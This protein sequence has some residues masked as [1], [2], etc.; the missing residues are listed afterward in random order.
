VRSSLRSSLIAASV[1]IAP[2]APTIFTVNDQG[3]E[4]ADVTSVGSAGV[5][6]PD[7]GKLTAELQEARVAGRSDDG[8]E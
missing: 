1:A 7:I 3:L 6:F 8:A 4:A 2:I 5:S